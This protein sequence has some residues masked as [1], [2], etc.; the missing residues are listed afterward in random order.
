[1]LIHPEPTGRFCTP[2]LLSSCMAD[3]LIPDV[4]I[5]SGFSCLPT[6]QWMCCLG[7]HVFLSI[8]EVSAG[9]TISNSLARLRLRHG[10]PK[11]NTCTQLSLCMQIP[12]A[13]DNP[14]ETRVLL[15]EGPLVLGRLEQQTA[16]VIQI[17]VPEN[18]MTWQLTSDLP[19]LKVSSCAVMFAVPYSQQYYLI[20]FLPGLHL[21][22]IS[23]CVSH[24]QT[25]D[26]V[27]CCPVMCHACSLLA[28]GICCVLGTHS[29]RCKF[30]R[31]YVWV[32]CCL[33]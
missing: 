15:A 20:E 2:N 10:C 8:S 21:C 12:N 13:D 16:P 5:F 9:V 24:L 14:E 7:C 22:S 31:V 6:R 3:A 32:S 25:S 23:A 26:T 17:G 18:M 4:S 11:L 33:A 30:T 27:T 29:V 19:V 28:S 1:M